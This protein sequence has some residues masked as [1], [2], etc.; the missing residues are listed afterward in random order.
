MEFLIGSPFSSPVGQRIQKATSAALQTED[1]SLNL[2][3]C[4]IINE[5]DDGP[6]VPH[7]GS[8]LSLAHPHA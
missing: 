5:T 6:G 4:D 1:W 3:I 7:D 2:E 8:G